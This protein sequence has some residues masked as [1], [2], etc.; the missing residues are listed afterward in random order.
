MS[1]FNGK[2]TSFKAI[3]YFNS[4]FSS[5]ISVAENSFQGQIPTEFG[6]LTALEELYIH[7]FSSDNYLTGNLP[8]LD[9]LTKLNKIILNH[10]KIKGKIKGNFL[11]GISD[12]EKAVEIG[13]SY[14][15]F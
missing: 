13:R 4:F 1:T 14:N 3:L 9:K 5:R 11:S 12:K 7:Q 2:M 6:L 15:R 8:E 10:N